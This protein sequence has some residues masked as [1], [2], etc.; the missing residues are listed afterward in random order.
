MSISKYAF[1]N[2]FAKSQGTI[3]LGSETLDRLPVN[4]LAQ[5]FDVKENIYN[6]SSSDMTISNATEQFPVIMSNMFPNHIIINLGE[7]ELNNMSADMTV[8]NLVEQYRWLLY[9]IHT[10][11]PKTQL[12][13]TSITLLSDEAH[14]FNDA[15]RALSEEFGC[16]FVALPEKPT[17]VDVNEYNITLFRVL[18][19][20]FYDKNLSCAEI[21]NKAILRFS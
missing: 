5:D 11:F 3:I 14:Q 17:E 2:Q 21:A 9:K 18:R 10:V 12:T 16:S 8:T 7:T 15:L 20:A 4:E 19:M 1:L 13:I 6:R